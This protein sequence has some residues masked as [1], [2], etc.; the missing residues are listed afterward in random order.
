M[1]CG[2]PLCFLPVITLNSGIPGIPVFGYNYFCFS[3]VELVTCL[4]IGNLSV[5]YV[6]LFYS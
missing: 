3:P 6:I 4:F 5:F 2:E 1:I